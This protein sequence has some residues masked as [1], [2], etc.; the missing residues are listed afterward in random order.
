MPT[1]QQYEMF[2]TMMTTLMAKTKE[3]LK[4]M[5]FDPKCPPFIRDLI[6]DHPALL[7]E[8][9]HELGPSEEHDPL[10]MATN[11]IIKAHGF[12]GVIHEWEYECDQTTRRPVCLRIWIGKTRTKKTL[13][14]LTLTEEETTQIATILA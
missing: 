3:D 7:G 11:A 8:C 14:V 1:D 13:R 12:S 4:G 9:F 6:R 10:V 2:R 5:L